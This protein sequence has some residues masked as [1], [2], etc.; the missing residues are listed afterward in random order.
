MKNSFFKPERLVWKEKYPE[1]QKSA[2][3]EPLDKRHLDPEFFNM[4]RRKELLMK[5][6]LR[7]VEQCNAAGDKLYAG[8]LMELFDL[9][10]SEARMEGLM[11]DLMSAIEKNSKF[12]HAV[13]LQ[14]K[15]QPRLEKIYSEMQSI[16]HRLN[17]A[18]DM[19]SVEKMKLLEMSGHLEKIFSKYEGPPVVMVDFADLG[20]GVLFTGKIDVFGFYFHD[21]MRAGIL[22]DAIENML[23]SRSLL[24]HYKESV[25]E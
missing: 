16:R 3:S 12:V 4:A 11:K 18:E 13:N 17:G 23:G 1:G 10:G 19:T 25:V 6:I 20:Q 22:F 21:N 15:L 8:R 2:S 5:S 24:S 14:R 7:R 9:L